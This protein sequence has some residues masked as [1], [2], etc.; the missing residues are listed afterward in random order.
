METKPY[1]NWWFLSLN[2]MI[3]I[4]FGFLVIFSNPAFISKIFLYTGLAIALTGILLL[5]IS[6]YS[7][8][9]EKRAALTLVQAIISLTIGIVILITP[10]ETILI[11]FSLMAGIWAITIGIFQLAIL[12]NIRKVIPNP[13]I[14]LFNGLLTIALGVV[15]CIRLFEI[16]GLM[17]RLIGALAVVLGA[18]LTYFSFLMRNPKITTSNSTEPD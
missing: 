15:L 3:F 11:Y 6:V 12:V 2:G 9:K 4:L 18:I 1:R 8:K 10:K 17:A 5:T 13:N 14:F 16:T 7:L